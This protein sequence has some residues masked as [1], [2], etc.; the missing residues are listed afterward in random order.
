LMLPN[1]SSLHML[2]GGVGLKQRVQH[3][4]VNECRDRGA[5]YWFFRYWHDELRPDGTVKTSRKRHIVGPSTGP[6][7]ISKKRAE[8]E[9]DRFLAELNAA[10]SRCEATVAAADPPEV[11]AILYGKL[12]EMWRRDFVERSVGGRALIAASTRAKYINLIFNT[13]RRKV[14]ATR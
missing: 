14:S 9:R 10:P 13:L 12:A 5:P 1:N 3:P 6:S 4:K 2:T 11:G 7:A 8:G